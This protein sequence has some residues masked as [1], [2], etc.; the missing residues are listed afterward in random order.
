MYSIAFASMV[1]LFLRKTIIGIDIPN[2]DNRN[3]EARED[4][5]GPRDSDTDDEEEL[6]LMGVVTVEL[7]PKRIKA[8]VESLNAPEV[9]RDVE[10]VP[11]KRSKYVFSSLLP[12]SSSFI[13]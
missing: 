9:L 1:S 4:S 2:T 6:D 7:Y 13:L 12:W 11:E 3:Q 8:Y 5:L 10:K